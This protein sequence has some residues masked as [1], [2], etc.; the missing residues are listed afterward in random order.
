M[1]RPGPP[2]I[3]NERKRRLGNPSRRPLPDPATMTALSAAV[4]PVPRHLGTEGRELWEAASQGAV[5]LAPTDLPLLMLA[6]EL[7]DRRAALATALYEEGPT[8]ANPSGRMVA[9]P[10]LGALATVERQLVDM[11]SLLGLT[12]AD[13][14]RLGVAEVR[15]TNTLQEMIAKRAKQRGTGSE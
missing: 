2:P 4:E 15:A 5:W 11:L 10:L 12:P 6:G 13:R 7:A 3:P 14:T 9:N 1:A 8:I